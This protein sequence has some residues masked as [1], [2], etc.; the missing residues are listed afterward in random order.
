[1]LAAVPV[2]P[3]IRGQGEGQQSAERQHSGVPGIDTWTAGA[4][5]SPVPVDAQKKSVRFPAEGG[6]ISTGAGISGAGD[7][8]VVSA[9]GKNAHGQA[10]LLG[11]SEDSEDVDLFGSSG[12]EQ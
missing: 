12:S 1:M 3:A 2:P 6:G 4:S 5:S 10:S 9:V 8:G 11:P 7:P